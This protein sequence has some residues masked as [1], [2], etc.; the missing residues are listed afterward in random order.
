[1]NAKERWQAMIDK[2]KEVE[3]ASK[4]PKVVNSKQFILDLEIME[5]FMPKGYAGGPGKCLPSTHTHTH[6]HIYIYIY[7]CVFVCVHVCMYVCMYSSHVLYMSNFKR[8][9][10]YTQ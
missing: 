5:P 7:I 3:K 9:P 8:L 2:Q 10:L 1:M 4:P 6:T